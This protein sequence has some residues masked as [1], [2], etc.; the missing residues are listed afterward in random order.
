VRL[1]PDSPGDAAAQ[2]RVVNAR[3][4]E[5]LAERDVEVAG[6]RAV[7]AGLQAQVADLAAKAGQNS[8]N[9]LKPSSSDG[10]AKPAP[11]S[12]RRSPGGSR[13]AQGA[14]GRDDAAVPTSGAQR[15]QPASS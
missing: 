14:A 3:L 7:V 5:L 9:S 1:V 8:K 6:L 4:R 13:P 10:L 12:L 11:K 15:H 2:L